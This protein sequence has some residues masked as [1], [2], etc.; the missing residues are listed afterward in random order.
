MSNFTQKKADKLFNQATKLMD[1]Y[2]DDEAIILFKKV[3]ELDPNNSESY[4]NIGLIYKYMYKWE[5]S[6]DYNLKA[7]KL[8]PEDEATRWNMAIAATALGKWEIARKAWIDNGFKLNDIV[9]PIELDMGI[10]PVRLNPDED[11]EVVWGKRIDPVRVEIENIPYISSGFSF[12]DIVLHDGAPNGYR[13]YNNSEYPVFDV[14]KLLKKSKY[15]TK[16]VYVK[17]NDDEDLTILKDLFEEIDTKFEDWTS[18]VRMICKQCSEGT[19]HESHDKDLEKEW[20]SKRKLGVATMDT[21]KMTNILQIWQ[22][23]TC[24]TVLEI[25]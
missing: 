4:Y 16:E 14:M 24:S 12:G 18:S 15:Q 3:I 11:A 7:Y 5:L 21:T 2:K 9:G 22:D 1:D 10:T 8:K 23:K 20:S 17:I 13:K 25:I 6:L 19:P